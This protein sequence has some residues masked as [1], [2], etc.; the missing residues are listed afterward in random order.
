MDTLE[1]GYRTPEN[2][3]TPGYAACP[4]PTVD[5]TAAVS[6]T[7][8]TRPAQRI[9]R[10][11]RAQETSA[12]HR[13]RAVLHMQARLADS[14]REWL[15]GVDTYLETLPLRDDAKR[16]R[17]A[18]AR[19]VGF[20][21]DWKTLT[22]TTLTW[23]TIAA[24]VGITRRSVARHLAALHADGWIGRV[25]AGRSAAAKLAA[26]WTGDE[27]QQNEAPVYVLTQ[28]LDDEDINVTPPTSSGQKGSPAR[29]REEDTPDGA[30]SRPT[31][32]HAPA[33]SGGSPGN[34]PASPAKPLWPGHAPAR[35]KDERLLAAAEIRHRIPALRKL[36]DRHIA[37]VTRPFMLA[38]WT[39]RDLLTALDTL[40]DGRAAGHFVDG[41]WVPFSGAEGIPAA[42]LGHW[43]RFRLAHWTD[44]T[45]GTPLEAPSHAAA[46]RRRAADARRA[47]ATRAREEVE[48]RRRAL[49]ADPEVQAAKAAAMQSIRNLRI[50]PSC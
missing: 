43:L 3:S 33:A 44:P 25:A 38:G 4:A 17:R 24:Q 46:R 19:M 13:G 48:Q 32:S 42:R 10:V 34:L 1:S 21:A 5:G 22:T 37:S 9:R 27:A 14:Q 28:P 6:P 12:L 35:R 30:A 20:N 26:G 8:R 50:R 45:A 18:I 11:S 47:A 16:H 39:I 15:R 2:G 29:A 7:W 49:A 40:P 36:T 41:N 31:I 23:G